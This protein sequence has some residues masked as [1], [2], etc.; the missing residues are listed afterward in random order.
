MFLRV[1]EIS[2]AAA[3]RNIYAFYVENTAITFE[4]SVPPV[5]DF[6]NRINST[7]K[8]Y[9]Y[10]VAVEGEEII[11]Y[12]YAGR[13]MERAAYQWISSLSVYLGRHYLLGV[14]T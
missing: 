3:I 1:A 12:T 14:G 9:P 2:D 7:L 11:G 10:L 4:V 13:Q 5:S 6:E 8:E